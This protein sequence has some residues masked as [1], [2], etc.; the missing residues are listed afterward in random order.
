MK[1]PTLDFPVATPDGISIEEWLERRDR[2]PRMIP[3]WPKSKRMTLVALLAEDVVLD[4][5]HPLSVQDVGSL[6]AYVITSANIAHELVSY[7]RQS[8]GKVLV[9]FF[10]VLKNDILPLCDNIQEDSWDC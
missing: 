9:L 5:T 4:E 3:R 8:D 2:E 6:K 1:R 10:S 7:S